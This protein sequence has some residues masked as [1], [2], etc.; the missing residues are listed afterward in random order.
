[1][2]RYEVFIDEP[3]SIDLDAASELDADATDIGVRE[4]L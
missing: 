2:D 3:K 1:M 4:V